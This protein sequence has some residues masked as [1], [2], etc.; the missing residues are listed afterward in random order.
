MPEAAQLPGP[1]RAGAHPPD[2]LSSLSLSYQ[3]CCAVRD[4]GER[5][6]KTL[7]AKQGH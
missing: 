7:I 4:S 2:L 5:A 6:I 1:L 3:H